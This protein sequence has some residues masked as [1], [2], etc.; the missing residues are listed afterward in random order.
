MD[1]QLEGF[2]APFSCQ[3]TLLGQWVRRPSFLR[4]LAL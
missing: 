1:F 2:A 4:W 3:L